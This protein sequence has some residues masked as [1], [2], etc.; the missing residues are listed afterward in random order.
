MVNGRDE[1]W[2][3]TPLA[4][5]GECKFQRGRR[6]PGLGREAV[7]VAS[8]MVRNHI[9]DVITTIRG[10][11]GNAGSAQGTDDSQITLGHAMGA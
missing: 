10:T 7:V 6:A 1:T 4:S 9:A 11:N 5:T 2:I 3:R 8:E